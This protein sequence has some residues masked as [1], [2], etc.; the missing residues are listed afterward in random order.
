M[1]IAAEKL[2]EWQR[3]NEQRLKL[4]R[5]SESIK[6]RCEQL[7]EEFE[8]ELKTSGKPSI[9]RSGFTL[10]WIPASASVAWAEEFIRSCGPEKAAELRT[11]AAQKQSRKLSIVP[12]IAS[13]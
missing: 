2:Q 6:K 3:L 9:I 1:A 10:C 8:A 12:P 4:N 13:A 11:A 5:E 7:E